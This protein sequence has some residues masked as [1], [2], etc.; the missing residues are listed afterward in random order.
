MNDRIY[1]IKEVAKILNIKHR[2]IYI[3]VKEKRLK[4]I[5]IGRHIR[6]RA[7]DLEQFLRD[8]EQN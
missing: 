2:T 1:N 7:S 5:K 4:S 6:I 3:I 8:S